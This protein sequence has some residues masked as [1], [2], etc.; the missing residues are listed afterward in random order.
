M[1]LPMIPSI[2]SRRVMSNGGLHLSVAY[3]LTCFMTYFDYASQS[4]SLC[5]AVWFI[6]PR[7]FGRRWYCPVDRVK[8]D[9]SLAYLGQTRSNGPCLPNLGQTRSNG[10]C[11]PVGLSNGLCQTRS[12]GLHLPSF[13]QTRSNGP[14]LPVGRNL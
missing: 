10:S 5:L 1:R 13:G 12:Y 9:P 3:E 8:R 11:L 7:S 2:R 6:M 14:C 4:D